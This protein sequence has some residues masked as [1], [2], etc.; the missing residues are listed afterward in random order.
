MS[1]QPVSRSI[2]NTQRKPQRKNQHKNKIIISLDYCFVDDY[3][4]YTHTPPYREPI[5]LYSC[6]SIPVEIMEM[7]LL[8]FSFKELCI[9]AQTSKYFYRVITHDYFMEKLFKDYTTIFGFSK[10]ESNIYRFAIEKAH[11]QLPMPKPEKKKELI[12]YESKK[13][14]NYDSE[15]SDYEGCDED[16][17]YWSE[18]GSESDMDRFYYGPD[19][20]SESDWNDYF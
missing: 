19:S 16:G 7:I 5:T 14:A 11:S 20:E 12:K 13:D 4:K 15:N 8:Y 10:P 3:S 17:V 18:S 6:V 1:P 9:I 2:M